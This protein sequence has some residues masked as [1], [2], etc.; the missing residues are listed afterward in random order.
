[1][2]IAAL[3]LFFFW[4][5]MCVSFESGGGKIGWLIRTWRIF[6]SVTMVSIPLAIISLA[7]LYLPFKYGLSKIYFIPMAAFLPLIAIHYWLEA[8]RVGLFGAWKNSGLILKNTIECRSLVIYVTG[9]LGFALTPFLLM[10]FKLPL[11]GRWQ[12]VWFVARLI[13]A[14]AV[15]VVTWLVTIQSLSMNTLQLGK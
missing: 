15:A 6:P 13:V 9:L 2:P 4:Q 11:A 10:M 5:A 12:I 7:L 3:A 8:A 14:F 1:L